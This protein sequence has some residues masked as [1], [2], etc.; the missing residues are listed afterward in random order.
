MKLES[1]VTSLEISKKLKELGVKQQSLF[2]WVKGEMEF[3]YEGEWSIKE[4][5]NY[6]IFDHILSYE[7]EDIYLEPDLPYD[8]GMSEEQFVKWEK[9]RKAGWRRMRKAMCSAFTVA[10]LGNLL[11]IAGPEATI[12]AYGDLHGFSGTGSIGS[13]GMLWLLTEPDR[14]AKMLI[15]LIE[16]KL[17]EL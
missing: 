10:E 12:K 7:I 16:N 5:E 2:R 4:G 17:I 1:Q 8:S 13:I 9:E 11:R 3:G 14:L 15:Y 6:F